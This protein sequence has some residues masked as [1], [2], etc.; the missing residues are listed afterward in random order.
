MTLLVLPAGRLLGYMAAPG[1]ICHRC[2]G[3]ITGLVC[4]KKK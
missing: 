1:P 2:I 3:A 4:T